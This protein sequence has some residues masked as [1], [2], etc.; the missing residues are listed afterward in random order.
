M[1]KPEIFESVK[2]TIESHVLFL[3]VEEQYDLAFYLHDLL[4][5]KRVKMDQEAYV[6]RVKAEIV[7]KRFRQQGARFVS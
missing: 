3:D 2:N 1:S 4:S 6:D 7:K 5:V